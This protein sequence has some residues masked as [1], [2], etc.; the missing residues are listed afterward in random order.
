M[1]ISPTK[2]RSIAVRIFCN[3]TCWVL[4]AILAGII[5]GHYFPST[6]VKM[7]V[8]GKRFVDLIKWFI[9]PIIFFTIVLGI[10]GMGN[11]KKVGRIGV[12]A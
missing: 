9:P 2:D 10:S 8:L 5:V 7:E 6:G 11:L 4:I 3:L 1:E 12:K